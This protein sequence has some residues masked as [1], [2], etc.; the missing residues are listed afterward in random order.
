MIS[1]YHDY[2]QGSISGIH[3][4]C[5]AHRSCPQHLFAVNCFRQLTELSACKVAWL[6]QLCV[7][8]CPGLSWG[9]RLPQE[10]WFCHSLYG[11][12]LF[13]VA[14]LSQTGFIISAL[15]RDIKVIWFDGCGQL[16]PVFMSHAKEQF[17]SSFCMVFMLSS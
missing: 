13:F 15:I 6:E 9:L 4:Q 10:V 8:L 17:K 16:V 3:L 2:F 11:G 1:K 12:F 7:G 5:F 14:A